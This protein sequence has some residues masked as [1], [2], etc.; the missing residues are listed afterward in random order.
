MP[1]CSVDEDNGVATFR[2]TELIFGLR[3][4]FKC[5]EE[6]LPIQSFA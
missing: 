3:E 1:A 5:L 6:F 2:A 4:E